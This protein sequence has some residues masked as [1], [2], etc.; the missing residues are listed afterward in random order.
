MKDKIKKVELENSTKLIKLQE[1][2]L[3]IYF[4]ELVR[5]ENFNNKKEKQRYKVFLK[6]K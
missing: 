1:P 5:I 4:S 3:K 2:E 6:F